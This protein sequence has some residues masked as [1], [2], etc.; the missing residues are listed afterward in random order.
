MENF[1]LLTP[2]SL[3]PLNPAEKINHPS[4]N[5]MIIEGDDDDAEMQKAADIHSSVFFQ[6]SADFRHINSNRNRNCA[7]CCLDCTLSP[8]CLQDQCCVISTVVIAQYLQ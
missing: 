5:V 6:G 1:S 2:R 4:R 7:L 3:F 8:V